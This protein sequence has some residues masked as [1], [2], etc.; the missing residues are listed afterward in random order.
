[1]CKVAL[2]RQI[3]FDTNYCWYN[4]IVSSATYKNKK[5]N[6]YKYRKLILNIWCQFKTSVTYNSDKWAFL[7]PIS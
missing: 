2:V 3:E 1:M 6:K 4:I 7:L 5:I